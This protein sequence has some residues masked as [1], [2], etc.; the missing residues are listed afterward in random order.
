MKFKFLIPI[1]F[2]IL[3][4]FLFGKVIFSNYD[5]AN[6]LKAFN[7]GEK[8]YFI[9]IASSPSKDS[10]TSINSYESY[11][12]LLE[13]DTYYLYGGISKNKDT[14]EYIKTSYEDKKFKSKIVVKYINDKVQMI[15]SVANYRLID[16]IEKQ[17]AKHD[18]VMDILLQVNIA[19][20]ESKHGFNEEEM[21]EVMDYLKNKPHLNPRGLMMMAP[22]IE[23]EETRQYFKAT[24][25]LLTK[26][27]ESYPNYQLTELS[28]GMT[29]DFPIA[30][31]EGSTMV[32]LGHALFDE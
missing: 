24:K 19:K 28:M 15:H 12:C 1:S 30:V 25:D 10:L 8:V 26:L 32:R 13:N 17:A 11:L 21:N 5:N 3:I 4:G 31:A 9:E 29:H 20:E 14:D 22:N 2:S 6:T 7:E 23:V 16:E 27:Q 18:L